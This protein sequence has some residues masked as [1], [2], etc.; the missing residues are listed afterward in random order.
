MRIMKPIIK[1]LVKDIR[2]YIMREMLEFILKQLTQLALQ[3]QAM[4][5]KEKYQAYL[6]VL[7]QLLSWFNRGVGIYKGISSF[8]RKLL[9]RLKKKK[10]KNDID[11][12]TVLDDITYADILDEIG[13][14]EEPIINNC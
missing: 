2:D 11:L 8:L 1:Q 13:I 10:Y 4:V 14:E 6:D 9:E 12:P 3:M 5:I 7:K